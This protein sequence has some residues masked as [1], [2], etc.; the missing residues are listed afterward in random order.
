MV[1]IKLSEVTHSPSSLLRNMRLFNLAIFEEEGLSI[2]TINGQ[3]AE[4]S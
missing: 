1:T 3:G 2:E 4:R